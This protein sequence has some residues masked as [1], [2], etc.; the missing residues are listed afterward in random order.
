MKQAMKQEMKQD[1]SKAVLDLFINHG[2]ATCLSS[3][4]ESRTL[5]FSDRARMRLNH[6][7][8]FIHALSIGDDQQVELATK[9]AVDLN[10][11]LRYLSGYGGMMDDEDAGT[12]PCG[13]QVPDVPRFKIVL[14]D[15][16]TFGGFSVHWYHV[17]GR[18]VPDDRHGNLLSKLDIDGLYDFK[19]FTEHCWKPDGQPF[20]DR[21]RFDYVFYRNGGLLL[22]GLGNQPFAVRIGDDRSYWSI[23]T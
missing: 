6:I 7:A 4:W 19:L 10:E 20:H 21:V 3:Q 17:L 9:L 8:G 16:G 22:H 23:H 14:H 1:H 12:F 18:V 15:D 13:K 11:S 5:L 2:Y